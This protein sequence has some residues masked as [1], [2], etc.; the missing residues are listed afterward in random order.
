M[1][2]MERANVKQRLKDHFPPVGDV[3]IQ[4]LLSVNLVDS[5][6]S[7]ICPVSG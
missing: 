4:R 5:V 3:A 1:I 6:M 2:V 7:A